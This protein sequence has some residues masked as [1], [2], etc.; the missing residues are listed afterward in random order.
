[1]TST[2]NDR[3]DGISTSMAIKVPVWLA[4]TVNITLAAEQTVDGVTTSTHRVLVK[5]QTDTVENGIYDTG[6]GDWTRASDFDGSRDIVTGTQVRV[7]SG[8]VNA[9]T[10][11]E[12][13]TTGVLTVGETGLTFGVTSLTGLSDPELL[14]ISGLTSAADKLPYFTG[15]GT[16]ALTTFT[17]FARTVLD[18][19]TAAA[20]RTTLGVPASVITTR[21]DIIRGSSAGVDERLAIGNTNQVLGNDGTDVVWETKEVLQRV[22]TQ[23]GTKATGTT[24]IPGDDNIPQN[25]QG[26]L[27]MSLAITPKSATSILVI[28]VVAFL[29]HTGFSRMIMALFQ[30]ATVAALAAVMTTQP[31]TDAAMTSFWRHVMVSGTTSATTFKIHAGSPSA[32]TTTFNGQAGVRSFGGVV[33][34]GIMITEYAT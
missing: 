5:N 14:A 1:M 4:T 15:S 26:F 16:A 21:G 7:T 32:G 8:T 11:W 33:P 31:A 9:N 24:T 6:T 13:L 2:F 23:T 29:T 3:V 22:S 20:A 25:T 34:S 28:E 17:S 10:S 27:I 12:I 19:A 30:D 18:D